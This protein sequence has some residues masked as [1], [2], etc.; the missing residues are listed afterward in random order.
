MARMSELGMG[1]PLNLNAARDYYQKGAET[2]D[3]YCLQRLAEMDGSGN[4]SAS[5][6]APVTVNVP[7]PQVGA[8]PVHK[9]VTH[10]QAGDFYTRRISS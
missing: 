6:A 7:S 10:L 1:I 4:T 5:G 9:A 2:G 8:D 3:P